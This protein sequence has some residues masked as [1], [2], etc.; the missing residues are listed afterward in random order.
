MICGL[1]TTVAQFW[2]QR[3]RAAL[4]HQ[5]TVDCFK[6][7]RLSNIETNDNSR[8]IFSAGVAGTLT[9]SDPYPWRRQQ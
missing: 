4:F 9:G 1:S 7:I 5:P 2:L 3:V 8:S 6:E